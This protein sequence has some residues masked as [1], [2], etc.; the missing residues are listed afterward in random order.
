V[1]VLGRLYTKIFRRSGEVRAA[2]GVVRCDGSEIAGGG[3]LDVGKEWKEENERAP[4]RV[5][6]AQESK[7]L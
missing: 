1:K 6:G 2:A 4:V 3:S 7:C 5:R